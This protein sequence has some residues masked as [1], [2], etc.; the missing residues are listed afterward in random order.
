MSLFDAKFFDF[1]FHPV[2]DIQDSITEYAIKAKKF[3]YS[4]I[5][6]INSTINLDMVS[7]PNNFSIYSG[8][9]I[10]CKSFKL[11][12][13][14]K[15]YKDKKDILIVRG[16][17][18]EFN[19][20]AVETEGLDI[21]LQPLVFNH[22]LARI[23]GDNSITLG[24]NISSIIHMRGEAR[25]RELVIM[26]SNLKHARKYGLQMIL[27]SNSYS[28]YDLRSPRE[29]AALSGLFGMTAKEA[30]DAM[31][32]APLEIIKRK[33]PDYIQEGIEIL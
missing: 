21:L 33:D 26:R 1:N 29:M 2:P 23:A 12:D 10:S 16:G 25:T 31:S 14:I 7:K 19:R 5:A 28:H 27:A 4:G 8:I 15:K 22:I 17:N 32:T 3:G 11:R 18:E 13:E 30:V 24:F 20:T 9:E 6:V